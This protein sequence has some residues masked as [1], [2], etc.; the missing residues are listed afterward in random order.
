MPARITRLFTSPLA[1]PLWLVLPL[2]LW[3]LIS[4]MPRTPPFTPITT[5]EQKEALIGTTI[6]GPALVLDGDM[7]VVDRVLVRLWGMDAMEQGQSCMHEGTRTRN[8]GQ[9]A[10]DLLEAHAERASVGCTIAEVDA[11]GR[12][13]ARCYVGNTDLGAM[14][15]HEGYALATPA[16]KGAY[17][18]IEEGARQA[19]SGVWAGYFMQP[20]YVQTITGRPL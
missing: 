20:W 2:A 14:L 13:I 12:A 16:G 8:C 10:I 5:P 3:L 9:V 4:W 18:E 6:A 15:V 17:A 7:I 1:R 19:K 11:W